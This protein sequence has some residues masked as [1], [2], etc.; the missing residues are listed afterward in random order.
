MS[1]SKDSS[2]GNGS[3]MAAG[4]RLGEKGGSTL[5]LTGAAISQPHLGA[6]ERLHASLAAHPRG[7]L[8]LLSA[9]LKRAAG[10]YVVDSDLR[11][12]KPRFQ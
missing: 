11:V 1:Q 7:N 6:V 10:I 2:Q 3:H 8:F 4:G 12:R 9:L 5:D